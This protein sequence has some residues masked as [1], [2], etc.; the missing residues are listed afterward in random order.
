ML[1][2]PSKQ[3]NLASPVL[4]CSIPAA[5]RQIGLSRSRVYELLAEGR[6]RAVKDGRRRLIVVS[7]LHEFVESLCEAANSTA[8]ITKNGGWQ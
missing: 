1:P 6:V 3:T 7:S 2:S 8:V 4:L 5:A